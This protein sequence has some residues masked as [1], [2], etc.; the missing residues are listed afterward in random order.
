MSKIQNYD[1]T[2]ISALHPHAYEDRVM[3]EIDVRPERFA[4]AGNLVP[5]GVH[6]LA[7]PRSMV[8]ALEAQVED[9]ANVRAA[10]GVYERKHEAYIGNGQPEY[11]C[12]LSVAG[13]FQQMFLRGIR[14]LRAFRVVSDET[15]APP[16]TAEERKM[17]AFVQTAQ[18]RKTRRG[19]SASSD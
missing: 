4:C 17:A 13:E 18:Q 10:E 8:P 3:V 11:R 1:T 14:P 16:L 9:E 2:A 7:V 15:I 12:N 6:Q 19:K 5:S